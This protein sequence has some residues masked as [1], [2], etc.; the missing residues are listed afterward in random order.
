[1]TYI[2]SICPDAWDPEKLTCREDCKSLEG[3]PILLSTF[4]LFWLAL[5]IIVGNKTSMTSRIPF[6]EAWLFWPDIFPEREKYS[7]VSTSHLLASNTAR[8]AGSVKICQSAKDCN[9]S[10]FGI[11]W[12]T[13]LHTENVRQQW[14]WSENSNPNLDVTIFDALLNF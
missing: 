3:W 2:H 5:C 6:R 14:K 8:K 10:F 12:I 11:V 1:M 13:L 7:V 4:A 9:L